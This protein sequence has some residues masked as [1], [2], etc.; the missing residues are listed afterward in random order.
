MMA[1]ANV[2]MKQRS[3]SAPITA[4]SIHLLVVSSKDLIEQC[5]VAGK[6]TPFDSVSST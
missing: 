5:G 1:V 4:E 3:S 2:A 6:L